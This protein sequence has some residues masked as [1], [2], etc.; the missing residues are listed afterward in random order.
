ME[1][2]N[3]NSTE[4]EIIDIIHQF[5]NNK[6]VGIDSI[7]AEIVKCCFDVMAADMADMFHYTLEKQEFPDIGVERF[8]TPVYTSGMKLD[9]NN[10]RGITALPVYKKVFELAV[11]RRFEFVNGAFDNANKQNGGFASENRTSD[12]MFILQ[13]LI[14]RQLSL[15]QPLILIFVDVT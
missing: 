12:N 1:I 6:S 13:G 7:P 11:Q 8:R 14:Q 5:K 3:S 15:G 4:N 9:I 2:M 10:Y